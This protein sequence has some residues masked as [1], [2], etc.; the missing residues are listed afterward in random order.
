LIVVTTGMRRRALN[1]AVEGL[2]L[3]SELVLLYGLVFAVLLGGYY[4]A[5][6]AGITRRA[7]RIVDAIAP[8]V[9]PRSEEFTDALRRRT[10]LSVLVGGGGTRR[11]FESTVVVAA[12]LLTALIGSAIGN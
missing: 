8:L 12:P 4:T 9:D 5:A 2:D 10:D 6:E 1:A 3:P 7:D 11:S